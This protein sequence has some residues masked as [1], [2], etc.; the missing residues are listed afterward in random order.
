M[1]IKY[2]V[3]EGI[4]LKVKFNDKYINL[5]DSFILSLNMTISDYF[6]NYWKENNYDIPTDDLQYNFILF[7]NDIYS[8]NNNNYN[9]K[10]LIV[11]DDWKGHISVNE[12][13]TLNIV[14]S[15]MYTIIR[16]L[17][18]FK[19]MKQNKLILIKLIQLMDSKKE[20]TTPF[21]DEDI[22]KDYKDIYLKLKGKY[23]ELL[24]KSKKF[25]EDIADKNMKEIKN[26]LKKTMYSS[27]YYKMIVIHK[28]NKKTIEPYLQ[29][30]E[31]LYD[32]LK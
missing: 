17:S 2:K 12:D 3:V 21:L 11:E 24:Y 27:T 19:T 1:N 32:L 29:K 16:E 30:H 9:W 26:I 25:V 13:N 20:K 15:D 14:Y 5:G 22:F 31:N 7:N 10:S 4:K 8:I 6:W 23:D 18:S 28:L